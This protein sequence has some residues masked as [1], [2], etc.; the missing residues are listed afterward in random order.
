MCYIEC[1]AVGFIKFHLPPRDNGPRAALAPLCVNQTV[2]QLLGEAA[3]REGL[4]ESLDR[5]TGQ[6]CFLDFP[7]GWPLPSHHLCHSDWPG[8]MC[9]G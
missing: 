6:R 8:G 2:V 7:R 4:D 5:M 9:L 3:F 1:W